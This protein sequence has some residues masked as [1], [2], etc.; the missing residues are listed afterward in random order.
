MIMVFKNESKDSIDEIHFVTLI[1]AERG[2]P[3]SGRCDWINLCIKSAFL[4]KEKI[5]FFWVI[6]LKNNSV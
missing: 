1:F 5:L 2:Y 4:R 3:I 6:W